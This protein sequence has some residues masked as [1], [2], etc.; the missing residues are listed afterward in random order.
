MEIDS[1]YADCIV[2]QYWE[3]SEGIG[4]RRFR[5][6]LSMLD[7]AQTGNC[8]STPHAMT[9]GGAGFCAGGNIPDLAVVPA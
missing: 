8:P 4:N 3:F 1:K 9:I 2:Q 5:R 6:T 7:H